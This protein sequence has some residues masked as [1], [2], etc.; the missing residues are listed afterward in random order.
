MSVQTGCDIQKKYDCTAY[1]RP[2][3]DLCTH[4]VPLSRPAV[5]RREPRISPGLSVT[6]DAALNPGYVG[7]LEPLRA[8][9]DLEGYIISFNKGLEP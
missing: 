4:H 3:L 5:K 1:S 8:L 7:S 2:Y 6:N 9:D